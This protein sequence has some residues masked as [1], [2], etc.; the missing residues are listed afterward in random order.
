M[1]E[2]QEMICGEAMNPGSQLK[3]SAGSIVAVSQQA[4]KLHNPDTDRYG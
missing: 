4:R 2:E 1:Q 3:L